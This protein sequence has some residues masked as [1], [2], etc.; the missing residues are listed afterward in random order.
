MSKPKHYRRG[1]GYYIGYGCNST[2]LHAKK[3]C[4]DYKSNLINEIEEL[5]VKLNFRG[6]HLTKLRKYLKRAS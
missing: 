3:G 6:A 1:N 4:L 2:D 5:K